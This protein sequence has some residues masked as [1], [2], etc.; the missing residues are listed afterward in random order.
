LQKPKQQKEKQVY[1]KFSHMNTTNAE[2]QTS[3]QTTKIDQD[4]AKRAKRQAVFCAYN[5]IN[6]ITVHKLVCNKG[7]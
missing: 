1:E 2:K 3:K 4:E 6:V 7:Y 5:A